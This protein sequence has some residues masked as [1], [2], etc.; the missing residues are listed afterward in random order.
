M[1]A[2]SFPGFSEPEPHGIRKD[3]VETAAM[4]GYCVPDEEDTAAQKVEEEVIE[5][6][7]DVDKMTEQQL[8]TVRN[9]KEAQL[10]SRA[11]VKRIALSFS[12]A[13]V[14]FFSPIRKDG[15]PMPSSVLKLDNAPA[16][17]DEVEKTKKY[18]P[19]YGLTTPTV[20]DVKYSNSTDPEE[21]SSCMQIDLCGGIF[22]LPEFA[23][24]PPVLTF[25][26]V[27]ESEMKNNDRKVDVVPIIVEAFERRMYGFTMSS[28]GV[29]RVVLSQMYKVIR[30][31]GHGVL[32][33]AK[34]GAKRELQAPALAAGFQNP[35]EIDDLDP[36]GKLIQE[37]LG[38]RKTA[39][40]FF[41][42]F[43]THEKVFD[44][45]FEREVFVGLCHN[46]LHGGN[47]LLDSQGLVWLIDFATVKKDVHVLIDPTKF[48]SACLFLYLGDNISEDFV[49][50][51]AKLLSVTPDATTALPLSSTDE[52]IKDDPCAMFLV[53][54]LARLRYC[55]CIY[56]IGDEG[57]HNDGVPFAVALFSWSARMLSYNEP[58][59]FQKTRALYFALASAQRL[60]W[61]VGVD[62]GPVPLEWIGGVSPSVGGKKREEVEYK[63]RDL[64]SRNVQVR[65]FVAWF[66]GSSGDCRI[67]VHRFLDT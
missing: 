10:Y 11:K 55:I 17:Q 52:L 62:V 57:P 20:K 4:E 3:E 27:I 6:F 65:R 29:K 30:F 16:V 23:S 63:C 12:G 25:A 35:R 61:E 66:L 43:V 64:A 67:V 47:L 18:A 41:T 38:V 28:R 19:L 14:F 44:Q 21:P 15:T 60:L 36:E 40:D 7:G 42:E 32:N 48:V 39:R 50:S 1:A 46:D 37:V 2:S 31:V 53:D 8:E 58:N 26:S 59:L 49:H 33:R 24:A 45:K 5:L 51:I 9:L 56:E 34:E 13:S 22:G 54:L